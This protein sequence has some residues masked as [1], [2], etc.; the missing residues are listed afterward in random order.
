MKISFQKI[1]R[2][3]TCQFSNFVHMKQT[4][5]RY[6][7]LFIFLL[8]YSLQAQEKERDSIERILSSITSDKESAAKLDKLVS[9]ELDYASSELRLYFIK[10]AI[11]DSKKK[12][13]TLRLLSHYIAK[14]RFFTSKLQGDSSYIYAEKA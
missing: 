9:S 11:R 13:D 14:S 4:L 1:T 7:V 6:I 2:Q 3:I 5:F 8:A 10:K 12:K